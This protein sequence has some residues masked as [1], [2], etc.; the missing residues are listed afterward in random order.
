MEF[1]VRTDVTL[2][3]DMPEE[4]RA[5]LLADELVRGRVL[6][7]QGVI[8]HIWRVPG[9]IRNVGVW[10]ARNATE[11]HER[12]ATSGCPLGSTPRSPRSPGTRWT[13]PSEARRRVQQVIE[14][15]D[16][17]LAHLASNPYSVSGRES[18]SAIRLF[19]I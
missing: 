14:P 19:T 15:L 7:A 9:A 8:K 3:G 6:R 10:E 1:L 18:G 2:P 4:R 17:V 11:L 13:R 16:G 5:A 12:S